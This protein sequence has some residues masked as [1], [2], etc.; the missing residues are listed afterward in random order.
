MIMKVGET[1]TSIE[2]GQYKEVNKGALKAFFTL[3][4]YPFG[5]K[6]MDCRYFEK[7][8]Q[9]WFSFPQKEVK[10]PNDAKS[11]YI[12]LISYLDKTYLEQ[13]KKTILQAL[14]EGSYGQASTYQKPQS[15]LQDDSLP[16]W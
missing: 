10:K 4:E 16:L 8:G 6:I 7:D 3:V 13:L 9:H 14:K 1:G 5:R 12:P 11:D 2:I 15:A